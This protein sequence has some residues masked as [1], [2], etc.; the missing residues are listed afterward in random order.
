M[1]VKG[2]LEKFYQY[3]FPMPTVLVTCNDGKQKTNIIT[4]A[5]HTPISKKPPLYAISVAPSRYSHELIFKNKEF[6]VN[7]LSFEMSKVADFCGKKTGRKTDKIS[8][9]KLN[10]VSCEKVDVPYIKEA[11]AHLACKVYKVVNAG[12]HDI[13]LGEVLEVFSDEGVFDDDILNIKKILPLFYLGGNKYSSLD[14]KK[15]KQY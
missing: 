13:I 12:D 11:Y 7:F 8:E 10:F 6:V 9:S 3:A 5:W 14:N 15:K 1:K 2:K 4:I